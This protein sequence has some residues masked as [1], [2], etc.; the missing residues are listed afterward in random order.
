MFMEQMAMRWR[1][2]LL[3]V[4]LIKLC[5]PGLITKNAQSG[6]SSVRYILAF[7]HQHQF[8][9][10]TGTSVLNVTHRDDVTRL[11]AHIVY[12]R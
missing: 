5:F 12:A 9:K 7:V 3:S 4:D 1:F 10:F 6:L 2:P 11:D 8:L